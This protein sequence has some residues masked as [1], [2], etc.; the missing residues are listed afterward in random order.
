MPFA[1]ID[2][3]NFYASCERVFDPSL[4]NRPVVILSNNDGCVIARSAEAKGAGVAMGIPE[5]K[6]RSLI[7]KMNIAVRS[8]NYALYGDMSMR[9]METI[10]SITPDIEVYSIDEAFVKIPVSSENETTN[11][12][13]RIRKTVR[14]HTGI[15]VSVGIASTKTLAK[16]ANETAKKRSELSGVLYLNHRETVHDVLKETAVGDVWGVGKN[17]REM[18]E[19]QAITNAYQLSRMPDSWIRSNMNVVGL[20]TVWEL[21]GFSCL[22]I[23]KGRDNKKGILSSR[24]FG[25]P[26]KSHR[27][28]IESVSSFTTRAG[29]KLRAQKCV[30]SAVT[31][32]LVTSKYI[33]PGQAYKFGRSVTLPNPTANT[34]V[35]VKHAT[36]LA[37]MLFEEGRT[38]KKAWVMLS[39]IVPESEIQADLFSDSSYSGKEHRLMESLDKVNGK[40]GKQLV[41]PAS[42][43]IEQPWK[44]KQQYL[45]KKYTTSWDELMRVRAI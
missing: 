15:P 17:Y 19:R 31:V 32:T 2:C 8:S 12:G 39:G 22:G 25:F 42:N 41:R 29:E 11:I 30:A 13:K 38:Y 3:N 26:V 35:L 21:R 10:K 43:G 28:I 40:Y 6:I 24:S 44:M 9:V 34:S 27:N 4:K 5:F 45:S 20:R 16:I 14:K 1:L 36:G 23:E 33:N 37:S 18:L 7:R